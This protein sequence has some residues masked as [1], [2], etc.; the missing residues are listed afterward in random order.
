[1]ASPELAK[2]AVGALDTA[3]HLDSTD[4]DEDGALV[5]MGAALHHDV[6]A[7]QAGDIN[8]RQAAR[9]LHDP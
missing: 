4:V 8:L 7:R 1:V 5:M 2:L 3:V 6:D 9:T